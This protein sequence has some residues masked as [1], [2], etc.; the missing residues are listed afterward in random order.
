[1]K[2]PYIGLSTMGYD[3]KEMDSFFINSIAVVSV[4]NGAHNS[5]VFEHY[6]FPFSFN[7]CSFKCTRLS[8]AVMKDYYHVP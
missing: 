7:C 5:N 4:P 2:I 8:E 3:K 1:M 6:H